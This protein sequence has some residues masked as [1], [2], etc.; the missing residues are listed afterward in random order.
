LD[1][2]VGHYRVNRSRTAALDDGYN[3][4]IAFLEYKLSTRSLVYLEADSSRWNR[5]YQGAGLSATSTGF[6]LRIK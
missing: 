3:R 1:L 2:L 6:S 5:D 4:T